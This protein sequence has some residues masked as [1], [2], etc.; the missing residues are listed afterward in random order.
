MKKCFKCKK[1]KKLNQFYKHSGMKD[2]HLNKCILCTKKDT[3]TRL[4]NCY[5]DINFVEK[6]KKRHRDKY[7][8]LYKGV[9]SKNKP[10]HN[11]VYASNYPEKIKAKK[12]SYNLKP[13]TPNLHKHHW[14]YHE[15][16][17]LNVIWIMPK[18]HYTLHRF[19]IYDQEHFMYRRIDTL[20]LLDNKDKHI[21]WMINCLKQETCKA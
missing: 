19:I 20:E 8:R 3:E 18:D 12:L 4:L 7:H 6:E 17:A 15:K 10:E 9:V 5:K 14:S 21:N 11:R 13:P 16:D 2:G 1:N